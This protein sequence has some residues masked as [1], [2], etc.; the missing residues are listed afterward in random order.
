MAAVRI[1]REALAVLGLLVAAYAVWWL[2]S[3]YYVF[4]VY[5]YQEKDDYFYRLKME[6]VAEGQPVSIDR[7]IKCPT[8]HGRD[9]GGGS[10]SFEYVPAL[11]GQ[12]LPSGAGLFVPLAG[13][14][15]CHWA[16]RTAEGF[17][18]PNPPTGTP[19]VYWT[20]DYTK[21]DE[22]M[23]YFIGQSYTSPDS[24]VKFVS[25]SLSHAT[26]AEW[27]E[28][29][30]P[31]LPALSDAAMA[32]PDAEGRVYFA[33]KATEG[34]VCAAAYV[35]DANNPLI[36]QSFRNWAK[37]QDGDFFGVVPSEVLP[38]ARGT[39]AKIVDRHPDVFHFLGNFLDETGYLSD[40]LRS[41][42]PVVLDLQDGLTAAKIEAHPRYLASCK[43]G[44]VYSVGNGLAQ[45]G[46]S[47]T[48]S[49]L[50]FSADAAALQLPGGE[51]DVI[52]YSVKS[53]AIYWVNTGE[54]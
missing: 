21:P 30:A 49:R 4:G 7:V 41:A 51:I 33:E 52:I 29:A 39:L 44:G 27:Q 17:G 16:F 47:N 42:V 45:R 20:K 28:P 11:L 14:G 31:L 24:H 18:D 46:P 12:K 36:P 26:A 53:G 6:L 13:F 1:L 2:V 19:L 9:I 37:T 5:S 48:F 22:L 8:L 40:R 54:M 50:V 15:S 25:A 34:L 3:L 35:I 32:T 23:G 10:L 43:F 38:D